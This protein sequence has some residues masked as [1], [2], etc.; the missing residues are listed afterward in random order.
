MNLPYYLVKDKSEISDLK[1][2]VEKLSKYFVFN[3][4]PINNKEIQN[5]IIMV[6]K[7]NGN[8]IDYVITPFPECELSVM[9]LS[10]KN[11][12]EPK[13]FHSD[14][15]KITLSIDKDFYSIYF[16]YSNE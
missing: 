6:R 4:H 8:N 14:L 16:K 13:L 10:E 9:S 7:R 5:N 12:I 11:K 1:E 3:C 2:K 15:D